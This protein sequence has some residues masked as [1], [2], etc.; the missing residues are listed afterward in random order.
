MQFLKK[1]KEE[2]KLPIF[3]VQNKIYLFFCV[4]QIYPLSILKLNG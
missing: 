2:E 3:H 4:K 1:N